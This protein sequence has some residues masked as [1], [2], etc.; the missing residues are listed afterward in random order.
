MHRELMEGA[1][2]ARGAPAASAPRAGTLPPSTAASL[3]PSSLLAPQNLL[4]R[5][6]RSPVTPLP[7][8]LHLS[9]GVA[10]ADQLLQASPTLDLKTGNGEQTW[11]WGFKPRPKP[12]LHEPGGVGS[13]LHRGSRKG[14]GLDPRPLTAAEHGPL[15]GSGPQ[16][17]P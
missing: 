1:R 2:L 8:P 16:G 4:G 3:G 14:E 7:G 13:V 12:L 15:P 5:A 11:R 10:D 9:P 6:P 17:T